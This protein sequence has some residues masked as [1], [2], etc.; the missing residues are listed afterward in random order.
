MSHI[1]GQLV[2]LIIFMY[3]DMDGFQ[4][5]E[6]K[7]N[8]IILSV[9]LMVRLTSHSSSTSQQRPLMGTLL[10]LPERTLIVIPIYLKAQNWNYSDNHFR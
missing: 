4:K 6:P 2:E 5:K 3:L 8:I 9:H 10:Q 7:C 1:Y